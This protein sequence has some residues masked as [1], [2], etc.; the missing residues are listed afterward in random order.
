MVIT[1]YKKENKLASKGTTHRQALC[2]H[3]KHSYH[4]LSFVVLKMLLFCVCAWHED[5]L[6]MLKS[7]IV[8]VVKDA[9][10]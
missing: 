4:L 2:T 7:G 3:T 1:I 8:V 10:M 6:P 9:P 5:P